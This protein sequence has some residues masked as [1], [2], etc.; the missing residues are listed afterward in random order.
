[1]DGLDILRDKGTGCSLNGWAGL[2]GTGQ[3]VLRGI[4]KHR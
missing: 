3:G 1:M 2:T 4:V